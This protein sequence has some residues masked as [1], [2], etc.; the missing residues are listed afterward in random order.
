MEKQQMNLNDLLRK[1]AEILKAAD[2]EDADFDARCIAEFALKPAFANKNF[3]LKNIFIYGDELINEKYTE[4]FMSL[5]KK[6]AE[7]EP[8]QYLLGEWEFMGLNFK[9]GKGVLI[10]RP[11]TEMLVEFAI[12]SLKSKKAPVVFDLCSG[13]GCIAIS[14]A[15]LCPG[16]TVYAVEKSDEAFS[17]LEENIRLNNADGVKAIKGDILDKNLLTG[18]SA[19]LLLSNP[20]YI[21]TDD[22]A[23]LQREV[24]KEPVMALDGGKDGFDFYRVI[25]SEWLDRIVK[26]GA[27]AVECAEDQTQHICKLFS[28]KASRVQ[29]YKDLSG[30]PRGVTGII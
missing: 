3:N 11:E 13:S 8:L 6:R 30:L 18:V 16:A 1:G 10:P 7:G 28:E 15:K 5:I 20:P 27:F 4:S 25:A 24:K 29:E 26:G 17:F 14:V 9:V 2:I 22:I 21:R 19:D 12:D 23:G